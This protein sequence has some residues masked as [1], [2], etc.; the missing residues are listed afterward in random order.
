M[1]TVILF[2]KPFQVLSQFSDRGD[3]PGSA[4]SAATTTAG[5]AARPRRATL[6]DHLQAPAFRVAGRLDYDSEGL[7]LLTDDG[8]LQQQITHPRHKLWK[9]YW[10]QVEGRPNQEQIAALQAGVTLRDGPTLPAR[11]RAMEPP[12]TLWPRDPPVRMRLTVADSWLEIS[13]REGR[14]RQIRRMTAAVGLPTLRL[15]RVAIGDWTLEGLSPGAHRRLTVHPPRKR[16]GAKTGGD[17]SRR[18]RQKP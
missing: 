2:N 7:L 3:Q 16:S 18:R 4:E 9:T 15:I 12:T 1:A 11:V 8:A 6:A 13:I 10:A 5:N 14:N 17:Q